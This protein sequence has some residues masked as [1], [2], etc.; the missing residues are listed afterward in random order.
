VAEQLYPITVPKWGIEMQEG[1]ITGWHVAVG[2]S[3]A[4]G[5]ELIDI[6]TDKIVNT[7][8]APVSGVVRRQLVDEGETL[9]V[10][11]LLG[12]IAT[13]DA[14]D[15]EIDAFIEGFVPA[16]ASFGIDDAPDEETAEPGEAAPSVPASDPAPGGEVRVSPVA[17]RLAAKLGVDLAAVQGTGRN[18]RIS[19]EDVERAAAG[20]AGGSADAKPLSSRRQ[21]IARRLASAKQTIPHYYVTRV[22]DMSQVLAAK[23]DDVSINAMVI[24][25]VGDALQSHPLLNA[26][27]ADDALVGRSAVDINMAVDTDEGLTAPLLR[28]VDSMS[29]AELTTATRELAERTRSNSLAKEDLEAGGFTV[30]NLGG[31]GVEAFTAIINPPQTGI[32]AVGA[33]TPT[34]VAADDEVVIRPL[35]RVTLSS[36]HRVVDGADAA[37]FLAALAGILEQAQQV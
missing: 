29:A 11:E 17:R 9:K 2:A 19:K 32:L 14:S 10:G 34:P 33:V 6:E 21:T 15:G 36:D 1:T 31:L 13:G 27:F 7:M 20:S 35:M 16:D 5:D 37:R 22:V 28:G 25:A 18:G 3:V 26:H 30:S 4:K 24:K 23:T 8:E 12:V